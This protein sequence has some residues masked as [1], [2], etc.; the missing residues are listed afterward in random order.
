MPAAAPR[1]APAPASWEPNLSWITDMLAV[2]GSFPCERAQQLA[3]A[4]GISGIVDLRAEDSDDAGRLAEAGI[5]FLHLPAPDHYPPSLAMLEAGVAFAAAHLARG[6]RVLLHCEHGIGRSAL[7][8][9]CVLVHGGLE[10]LAALEL[11]KARRSR[12]SP[13][14]AQYEAW[15]EWL[16]HRG[17]AVPSFERFAAISYAH[18]VRA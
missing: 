16:A 17:R 4:L 1:P 7:L 6:N 12:V 2:G 14:P 5:D 11:A 9:L 15:A 8:A 13:S 3:Q 18:L 10:P